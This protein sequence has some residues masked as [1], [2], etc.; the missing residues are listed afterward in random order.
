MIV[1]RKIAEDRLSSGR[2]RLRSSDVPVPDSSLQEVVDDER[3]AEESLDAPPATNKPELALD[4]SSLDKLLEHRGGYRGQLDNQ[5]GIAETASII[6][7]AGARDIFGISSS[8]VQAYD[9]G[10]QSTRDIT[11]PEGNTNPELKRRVDA[12]KERIAELAVGKLG[13]TLELLTTNKLS[14]VGKATNLT[15]VGKDLAVI[16]DKVTP[17]TE[18]EKGN[19]VHF[20]VF[21][22]PT[23]DVSAY[24]QVTIGV[25]SEVFI[26]AE[27]A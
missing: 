16:L 6:G 12:A 18:T 25:A 5:V 3:P 15:K 27:K 13:D 17:R 26:D 19:H 10:L 22:P 9:R 8:Q 4:L 24:K 20:H 7:R 11:H 21:R 14:K 23:L 2:N 1:S